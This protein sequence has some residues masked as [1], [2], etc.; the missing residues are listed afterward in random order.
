VSAAGKRRLPQF[1]ADW[2]DRTDDE[3]HELWITALPAPAPR[4][5]PRRIGANRPASRM[6]DVERKL[7]V[8]PLPAPL[9]PVLPLDNADVETIVRAH[10]RQARSDGVAIIDGMIAVKRALDDAGEQIS[11][12]TLKAL[13]TVFVREFY[14]SA[15]PGPL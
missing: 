11:P 8:T 10:A 13:R 12:E 1:P 14:F 4:Q 3:M 2:M 9:K 15:R 7:P 5:L 6:T